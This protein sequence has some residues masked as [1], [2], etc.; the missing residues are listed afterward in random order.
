MKFLLSGDDSWFSYEFYTLS[1]N[2]RKS[3]NML[4]VFI[5]VNVVSKLMDTLSIQFH[6]W[7]RIIGLMTLFSLTENIR[8]QRSWIRSVVRLVG[9]LVYKAHTA[10][11]F[12]LILW[13]LRLKECQRFD[14]SHLRW[15]TNNVNDCLF[16][17]LRSLI[18]S[19]LKKTY[20][21]RLWSEF[22]KMT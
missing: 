17:Q 21:W 16:W 10:L 14:N 15:E 1:V 19:F 22:S 11:F 9:G 8:C 13:L 3:G 6:R 12:S 5:D 7:G 2:H 18:S 20:L 4:S